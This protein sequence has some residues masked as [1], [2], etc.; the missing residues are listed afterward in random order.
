MSDVSRQ[1]IFAQASKKL[2]QDFN[3]LSVVAHAS[4][5]GGEA[6]RLVRT[7]LE[8]HLPKRFDVGAGFIIDRFDNVSKQIDVIVYDALNCPVYRAS[9][10]AGIFPSDNVAATVEVKSCL[11]KKELY[12]AFDN[13]LATKQLAKTP[14]PEIGFVT[15][16]T[17]GC[18]FA[19]ESAISFEKICEHYTDILRSKGIGNHIDIILVLDKGVVSMWSKP[20]AFP[21]WG[22]YIHEGLAVKELS[23]GLHFAL[24]TEEMG[25][26]SLDLFLRYVLTQLTFFR[27]LVDHPG[28]IGRRKLQIQ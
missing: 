4:L 15:A 5:K 14:P 16:Q 12:S 1:N 27:G 21:N 23:E 19:F 28:L 10:E 7:F 11:D 22:R 9:E 13:I 3:E 26:D 24:A 18:V 8:E 20:P 17:M 2:R 6:E 25:A